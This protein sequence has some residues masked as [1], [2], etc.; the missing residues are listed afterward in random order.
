MPNVGMLCVE[1]WVLCFPVVDLVGVLE[2]EFG[3]GPCTT[4]TRVTA[5]VARV[6]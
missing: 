5:A 4:V 2:R 3:N 1:F 6:P